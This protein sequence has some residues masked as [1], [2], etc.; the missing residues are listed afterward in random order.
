MGLF[1]LTKSLSSHRANAH[2]HYLHSIA[3]INSCILCVDNKNS[4]DAARM[5]DFT[6]AISCQILLE[7]CIPKIDKSKATDKKNTH[8]ILHPQVE[9]RNNIDRG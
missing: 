1:H 7:S 3:A 5:S 4:K 2:Q 6:E 9:V 8:E